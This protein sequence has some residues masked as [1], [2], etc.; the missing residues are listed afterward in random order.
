MISPTFHSRYGTLK[1]WINEVVSCGYDPDGYNKN[2]FNRDGFDRAGLSESDYAEF[3][4]LKE[5]MSDPTNWMAPRENEGWFFLP[6]NGRDI[7]HDMWFSSYNDAVKEMVK[8][9]QAREK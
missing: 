6:F 5:L 4:Q 2:G 9:L 1:E 8:I 3:P 7:K